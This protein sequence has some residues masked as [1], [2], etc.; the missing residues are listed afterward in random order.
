MVCTPLVSVAQAVAALVVEQTLRAQSE[1]PIPEAAEAAA[2]IV[3]LEEP[4][5]LAS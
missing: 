1:L 4:A 5:A 3:L 2:E